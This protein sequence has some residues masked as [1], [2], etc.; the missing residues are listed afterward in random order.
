MLKIIIVDDDVFFHNNLKQLISWEDEGFTIC[1]TAVNGVEALN[2][3]AAVKPDLMITDMSM[4]GIN[5]VDLIRQAF[6]LHP[7]LKVIALSAYKDFHYV[8]ESLKMG[9]VDYLLKHTLTP[10]TLSTVLSTVK[11]SIEQEKRSEK[12]Q[13]Q[14]KEQIN[15][16]RSVLQQNFV[17][18]LIF[19]DQ[20]SRAEISAE[21]KRLAVNLSMKNLVVAAG[22]VDDYNLLKERYSAAEFSELIQSLL[23]IGQE[24]LKDVGQSLISPLDE[25]RFVIIFSFND[26]CSNQKIYN[27]VLTVLNRIRVTLKRYLNITASFGVSE[28]CNCITKVTL[29]YQQ[30]EQMLKKRFYHGKDQ[31]FYDQ[32]VGQIPE[33]QPLL[34][35]EEEKRL[36]ELVKTQKREEL[37]QVLDTVFSRIQRYQPKISDSKMVFVNLVGIVNRLIRD[38]ELP[39]EM[40]YAEKVNPFVKLEDFDTFQEGKEWIITLYNKL[41]DAME[42]YYLEDHLTEVTRAA[43]QFIQRNYQKPIGL[44]HIAEAVGVNCSYIS[45]KFKQECGQGVVEYLN[46]FRIK[47][48]KILIENGGRIIKEVAEEVGFSNYN[49]FFKV[50]KDYLGM[51]PLTYEK[52]CRDEKG[53][54]MDQF[55]RTVVA[56][57]DYVKA[58][59]R[60]RKRLFLS[61]DEW[62]VWADRTVSYETWDYAKPRLEQIYNLQ[63]ALVFGG[64][65]CT[66]LNNADRVKIACLAQLVNAI[67]PI[68]TQPGGAVIKQ[69][70]YYPFAQVSTL[71]RGVVLRP[72]IT[73]PRYESVYGDAPVLQLSAVYR[74]EEGEVNVFVLNCAQ[75]EEVEL[76]LDFRS[77]SAVMPQEHLVLTGPDLE[78]VNCF[79]EPHKVVPEPLALPQG[80]TKIMTVRLP[81]VS[82]NVLRFKTKK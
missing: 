68:L 22:V 18:K 80:D 40:I 29:F 47:K 19:A 6:T 8:K 61:F 9:A 32:V 17:K 50:F 69:T 53:F 39:S 78:A 57:A 58:K 34:Q 41:L 15:L 42:L 79:A 16:G 75:E 76:S 10:A 63:D 44:R 82:W 70:I 14:I 54:D 48:A 66:L 74:E 52:Y 12:E 55:I 27:Q 49:Y 71:G 81:R 33:K 1:G 59:K 24:I 60:S 31:V 64:L 67:A 65:L 51:T 46:T 21:I 20:L 7:R 37:N 13:S 3:I 5:G 72:L 26:L 56:A 23:N 28:I 36:L 30:A 4:P 38:F 2:L 73:S 62:N 11:R 43:V 45:R 25:E 77:F 35:V